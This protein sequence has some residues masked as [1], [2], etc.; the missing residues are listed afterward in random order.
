M[1]KTKKKTKKKAISTGRSTGKK[2]A[3]KGT[4]NLKPPW[5]KGK[6]GNPKGPP[7]ISKELR[8]FRQMD[9]REISRMIS[10]WGGLTRDELKAC[11]NDKKTSMLDRL[12]ISLFLEG[13]KSASPLRFDALLNRAIGKVPNEEIVD[14]H[15]SDFDLKDISDDGLAE[16]RQILIKERRGDKS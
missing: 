4:A 7:K 3:H 15:S 10:K 16:I 9:R 6:S 14:I 2:S 5:K 1:P 12:V 8:Q 11:K 13:E